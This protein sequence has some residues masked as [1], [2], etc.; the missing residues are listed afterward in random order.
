MKKFK[1]LRIWGALF[2]AS[3]DPVELREI[4]KQAEQLYPFAHL[5]WS[6][7][8]LVTVEAKG[9]AEAPAFAWPLLSWI[10]ESGWEPISSD[11]FRKVE[12]E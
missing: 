11:T 9:K 8:Y 10:L 5:R 2:I 7:D 1:M 6:S 12:G 4:A 3:T